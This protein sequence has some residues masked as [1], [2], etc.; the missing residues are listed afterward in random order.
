MSVSF[1][2]LSK[3]PGA[4]K[5][6]N[7]QEKAGFRAGQPA[8]IKQLPRLKFPETPNA[9]YKL[10]PEDE[11]FNVILK[12]ASPEAKARI[13]E[14]LD[15]LDHE[16][17]R[18]FRERDFE[19]STNQNRYRLFQIGFMLLAAAATIVGS[20]QGLALSSIADIVPLL[21]L[22][23]TIIALTTT[24]LATISG[25]EPALPQ[26]LS[27]RR[28]AEYLRREYFRFLMNLRPYDSV[29]GYQRKLLLSTR[30]ANI[31]RGIYPDQLAENN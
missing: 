22:I 25:R 21:A 29:D 4:P 19:A 8:W 13:K 11:L 23:E 31:N 10:I 7:T 26:W 12:D 17:L 27:N 6:P 3:E 9:S 15:F 30:A 14:D 24:Y 28:R 5:Q 1:N 20:L 18:L 16:L 2:P